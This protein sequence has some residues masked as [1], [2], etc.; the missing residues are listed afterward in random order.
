MI[1][2]P[3]GLDSLFRS[4]FNRDMLLQICRSRT[5]V[6]NISYGFA[7]YDMEYEDDKD[8]CPKMS[9][10]GSYSRLKKTAK[11]IEF[12]TPKGNVDPTPACWQQ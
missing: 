7:L 9:P 8:D 6:H 5:A 4:K 3:L 10:S 11:L 2:M 12:L 1:D